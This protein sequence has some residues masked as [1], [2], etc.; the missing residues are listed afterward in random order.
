MSTS[1]KTI[2][3]PAIADI[4]RRTITLTKSDPLRSGHPLLTAPVS[5]CAACQV[6]LAEGDE[7]TMM[8]LGPGPDKQQR[9]LCA[10]SLSYQAVAVPLHWTCATGKP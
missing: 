10:D 3:V 5:R 8:P 4:C 7:I 2:D 1:P 6:F 9:E